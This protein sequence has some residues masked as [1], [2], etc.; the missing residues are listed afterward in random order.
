MVV[1]RSALALAG[2]WRPP[3]MAPSPPLPGAC[4]AESRWNSEAIVPKTIRKIGKYSGRHSPEPPSQHSMCVF[5]A[6]NKKERGRKRERLGSG[7]PKDGRSRSR[8]EPGQLWSPGSGPRDPPRGRSSP[9]PS[10]RVQMTG[11]G[12]RAAALSPAWFMASEHRVGPRWATRSFPPAAGRRE[13][14]RGSS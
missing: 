2:S 4:P 8:L 5:G 6:S 14:G 1:S 13:C 3:R 11:Q 10:S 7:P 12:P 9:R